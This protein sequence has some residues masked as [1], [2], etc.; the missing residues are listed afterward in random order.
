MTNFCWLIEAP[1]QRYLGVRHLSRTPSFEWTLDPFKAIAFR[2]EE[3]ANALMSALRLMDRELDSLHNHG[4]LC[5]GRLFGFEPSI[6][7]AK[8]VEHVYIDAG[9]EDG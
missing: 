6:G 2:S 8:A 9:K 5:W 4:K 7:N 3:Q 1:G